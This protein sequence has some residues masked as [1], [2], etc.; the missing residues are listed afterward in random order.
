MANLLA[1]KVD[2]AALVIRLGLAAIFIVHG[3]FKIV[4][5]HSLVPNLMS[6]S[7]QTL[8]GW[9]ELIGGVSVA[10]GLLSRLTSLAFIVHQ[11]WIIVVLTGKRALAGPHI[12]LA[13]AD[14]FVVGPEFNLVV[15]TLSLGLL[16]LGSGAVSVDHFLW[17]GLTGRPAT[18]GTG[19][20]VPAMAGPVGAPVAAHRD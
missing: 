12:N 15:I 14:Y 9:C 18:P 19:G 3:Y 11:V 7:V 1:P 17:R 8:V 6:D 5:D 4:Q 13:G 16:F 20:S 2:L 10:I